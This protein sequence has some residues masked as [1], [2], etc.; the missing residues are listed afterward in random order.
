MA[1]YHCH[2]P[3]TKRNRAARIQQ[4]FTIAQQAKASPIFPAGDPTLAA[5]VQAAELAETQLSELTASKAA[6]NEA[7]KT[8]DG[9]LASLHQVSAAFLGRVDSLTG[10][11]P[12]KVESLGLVLGKT[13]VRSVVPPTLT[14]LT[15][16]TLTMGNV[17][18]KLTLRWDR[19]KHVMGYDIER[20][21]SSS[22]PFTFLVAINR[23]RITLLKQPRQSR[24]ASAKPGKPRHCAGQS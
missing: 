9:T 22:G 3:S 23:S 12:A 5:F 14:Q 7:T 13:V 15:G 4:L 2:L 19:E 21:T 16:F 1:K 18:G 10:G 20:A 24:D 11:D 8:L 17:L 6:L